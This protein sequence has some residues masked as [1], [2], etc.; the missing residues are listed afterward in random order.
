MMHGFGFSNFG[1]FGW[2]GMVINLVVTLIVI[3]GIIWLVVWLVR[4]GIPNNQ[5][6]SQ[7]SGPSPKEILQS[8][9]A[10][11]EISREEY[12]QIFEDLG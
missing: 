5:I 4:K 2:I 7:I 12:K 3:G 8:R 9:Y 11:G 10:R 1:T 6:N